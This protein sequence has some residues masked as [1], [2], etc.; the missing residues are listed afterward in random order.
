MH[1][2]TSN[3]TKYDYN[4]TQNQMFFLFT[5]MKKASIVVNFDVD[6]SHLSLTLAWQVQFLTDPMTSVSQDCFFK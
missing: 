6:I 4:H 5:F 3:M 2:N 1:A